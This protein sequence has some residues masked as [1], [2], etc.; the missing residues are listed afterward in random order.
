MGCFTV[1]TSSKTR[2]SS[3]NFL[4][5]NSQKIDINLSIDKNKSIE[6]NDYFLNCKLQDGYETIDIKEIKIRY[7]PKEET[8]KEILQT[9]VQPEDL[10]LPQYVEQNLVAS[11]LALLI[12]VSFFLSIF[13]PLNI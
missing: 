6:A 12:V 10:W 1:S 13:A 9:S 8:Q 3:V 7:T 4:N 5:I 2:V 11:D